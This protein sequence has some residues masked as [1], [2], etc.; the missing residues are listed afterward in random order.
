MNKDINLKKAVQAHGF[1]LIE[2]MIV[3][4]VIGILASLSI[5]NNSDALEKTWHRTA[6]ND[7]LELT[8][9]LEREYL[10][11]NNYPSAAFVLPFV[12]SP[13]GEQ[14]GAVYNITYTPT[15]NLRNFTI[16]ADPIDARAAGCGAIT[17]NNVGQ[18]TTNTACD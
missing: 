14:G 7:L 5:F 18:W 13:R 2:L 6:K 17:L 4:A 10:R 9:H 8:N 12:T 1:T 3:I 15:A 16:T 11:T